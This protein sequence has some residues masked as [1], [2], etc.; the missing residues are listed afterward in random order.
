MLLGRVAEVCASQYN[1]GWIVSGKKFHT[2]HVHKCTRHVQIQ[3]QIHTNTNKNPNE[4]PITMKGGLLAVKTHHMCCS[5]LKWLKTVEMY[6]VH[7][8][9][10]YKYQSKYK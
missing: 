4:N 10:E 3:I 1:E 2:H 7:I 5:L 6:I 9:K 8:T